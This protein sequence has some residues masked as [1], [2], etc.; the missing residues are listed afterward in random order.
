VLLVLV[1]VWAVDVVVVFRL[2]AAYPP[3]M[4]IIT[5]TTTI[6]IVVVLLRA[7][8][9]RENDCNRVS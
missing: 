3:M 4:R 2:K 6:T 1:L 8:F 5:T 9:D 7:E